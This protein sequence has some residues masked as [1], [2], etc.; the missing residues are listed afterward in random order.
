MIRII[1]AADLHLD[2]PFEGLDRRRAAQ[3]R[4]EQRTLI[5]RI[6]A[7]AAERQ[8]DLLLFSGDLFD[9]NAAFLETASCLE[10]ALRAVRIPVFIAPGNHDYYAKGSPWTLLQVP[11]FQIRW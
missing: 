5:D 9:T 7:L 3:R 4:R 11:V 10:N 2:S 1:H 6:A 8:A